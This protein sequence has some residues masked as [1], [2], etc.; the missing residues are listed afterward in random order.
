VSSKVTKHKK[1]CFE[2]TFIPFTFD[3]FGFLTVD[4]VDFL[5]KVQKIMHNN[6]MSHESINDKFTMIDFAI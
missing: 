3:T 1:M 5:H 6:V 4:V 2:N